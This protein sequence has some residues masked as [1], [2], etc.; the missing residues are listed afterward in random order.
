MRRF[1]LNPTD[2][3]PEISGTRLPHAFAAHAHLGIT[4][5]ACLAKPDYRSTSVHRELKCSVRVPII[6]IRFIA[7][8]SCKM[9]C[10]LVG[11]YIVGLWGKA[12]DLRLLCI[13]NYYAGNFIVGSVTLTNAQNTN[14]GSSCVGTYCSG[15]HYT[16]STCVDGRCRCLNN[17]NRDQ[18]TCLGES[19]VSVRTAKYLKIKNFL[20]HLAAAYIFQNEL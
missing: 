17:P 1:W 5:S 6:M 7:P 8:E 14:C 11:V 2:N 12:F 16:G 10:V 18:C 4:I 15:S 13:Y 3:E 19:E 20:F 9:L